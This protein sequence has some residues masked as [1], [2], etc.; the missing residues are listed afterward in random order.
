MRRVAIVF[1]LLVACDGACEAPADPEPLPPP[2]QA[3]AL[4]RFFPL[5]PGNRYRF[6]TGALR[7]ASGVTAVDGNGVAAIV[8]DAG[9][10]VTRVRANDARVEI[11]DPAGRA[12]TPLLVAPLSREAS[13]R[14]A[15]DATSSCEAKVLRIDFD[16]VAAGM[17]LERCVEVET[18]CTLG[19]PSTEGATRHVR[20]DTYCPDVGRVRMVSRFDPPPADGTAPVRSEIVSWRVARGPLPPRTGDLCAGLILL[21]S[22]V[23]SAC[24][25]GLTV[26]APFAVT[27]E[28]VCAHRMNGSTGSVVV[29]AWRE[30]TAPP[31]AAP[32]TDGVVPYRVDATEGEVHFA[33][34]ATQP[35]CAEA[36]ATRLVP[37]LRSLVSDR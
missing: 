29:S 12:L 1:C 6:Q 27:E 35:P 30:G 24:G 34:D 3:I 15:P 33:I 19:A 22:D 26:S 20:T 36:S 32:M 7:V 13:W 25:A 5:T 31:E 10:P 28:G 8:D 4:T 21:P 16:E 23:V 18:T 14:F 17:T 37:L 11:T 2:V 9:S